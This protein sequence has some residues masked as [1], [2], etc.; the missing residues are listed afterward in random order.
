M[1]IPDGYGKCAHRPQDGC[2]ARVPRIGTEIRSNRSGK[3]AVTKKFPPFPR[4]H[5]ADELSTLPNQ[6]RASDSI[7]PVAAAFQ[8][9]TGWALD[10]EPANAAD[11]DSRNECRFA[12]RALPGDGTDSTETPTIERWQAAQL[13]DSISDLFAELQYLRSAVWQREAELAIGIPVS[14]RRQDEQHLAARL[15][16]MLRN[17]AEAVGCCASGLYLLD[18]ATAELKLRACW[19]LPKDRLLEPARPLCDAFAELEAL[20][21]HAVV[22]EDA[23]R[24]PNWQTPEPYP[25]AICLP[26][27]SPT[28]SL[29]TIWFF[30]DTVRDFGDQEIHLAEIIA[31]SIAAELQREVLLSECLASKQEQRQIVHAMQWQHDHLPTIKP[32]VDDWEVAGWSADEDELSNGFY[33]WLVP[34]DGSLAVAVGACDGLRADTALSSSALQASV[35]SHADYPHNASQLVSRVNET[36]WNSSAGGHEASLFYCQATPG[37]GAI[38]FSHAGSIQAILIQESGVELIQPDSLPLGLDPDMSPE[39]VRHSLAAGDSL[40]ILNTTSNR[41]SQQLELSRQLLAAPTATS[42]ELLQL[43]RAIDPQANLALILR[44]TQVSP[45]AG[46]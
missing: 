31:G 3:F 23:S 34:P 36:I 6:A 45:A 7:G 26:V 35:R 24:L 40:L 5:L 43:V 39:L 42:D 14:P 37:T 21:G 16:L 38:E 32:L 8:V 25:A 28:D 1:L 12:V 18:D 33:D 9:S 27:S 4:L 29:G 15:E 41:P 13:A 22:L 30:A 17:G 20:I 2:A 10:R 11:I 44:R 46:H 19:G